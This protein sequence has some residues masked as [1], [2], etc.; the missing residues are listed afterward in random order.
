MPSF[1]ADDGTELA[2]HVRGHGE[3]LVCLP[4]GP[5]R[6]SSYLSN[7]GGLSAHRQLIMLDL[8]GT[9]DSAVPAD[10][11][12]YRCDRLVDDVAR[13]TDHLGLANLDVLGHSAGANLAILYAIRYQRR[14]RKVILITPSGRSV[15][16]QVDD[17]MRR[18][19]VSLRQA[20]PWFAEAI[21]ALERGA[22]TEDDSNAI[23]PFFYGRWDAGAQAHWAAA[24]IQ[25]NEDAASG[26]GAEGAFDPAAARIAVAAFASPVL[27]LAGG[28]DPQW[29]PRAVGELA[30]MFP[31]AQLAVQPNAG[32]YPWLDDP[33]WFVAAV[34]TFLNGQSRTGVLPP[35]LL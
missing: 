11:A 16:L 31:T 34:T 19:I 32:H 22:D 33:E 26:F 1:R 10:P 17:E 6:A 21:A 15:G 23:A 7:L 14:I 12:S 25:T 8:R 18:E 27:V 28:V 3:P 35:G 5:G 20:E 2:Y 13:L 9:G 4:G 30:A 29:P 24:D